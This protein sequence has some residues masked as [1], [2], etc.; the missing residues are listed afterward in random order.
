V[1]SSVTLDRWFADQGAPLTLDLA[2]SG[3]V[4]LTLAELLDRTGTAHDE[5]LGVS[6]DYG[7]G[8]GSRRLVTAIQRSLGPA[9]DAEVVVAGGAV[10]ALLLLCLA[11]TAAGDVLVGTP[12]YGALLSAPAAA[13][14]RVRSAPVWSPRRGLHLDAVAAAV[15]PSTGLVIVNTPHNP[16]GAR[17]PLHDLDRLAD[18]CAR[19]GALLVVDEVARGTLDADAVSAAHSRGFA[20]GRTAIIGD[21]SKSLGLGGLRIGWLATGDPALADRVARAK[22]ATTVSSGTLSERIAAIALESIASLLEPV[23]AAARAN[24]A[25]LCDLLAATGDQERW[26]PPADGLVAFPALTS[27]RGAEGL[28]AD[29]RARQVGVVP[30]WLFGEPDRVRIGLGASPADFAEAML[31]LRDAMRR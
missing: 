21:V 16:T 12:A 28:V 17:I 6:L 5:L 9:G 23:R 27:S 11:T 22:D 18:R 29:L 13:G 25:M 26:T 7:A 24:L 19:H 31:R 30:G 1:A 15:T 20:A 10:E 3:A 14:R 4:S 8:R 2:R